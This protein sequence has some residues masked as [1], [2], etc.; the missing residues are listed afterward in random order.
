M[1][2]EPASA[3]FA[4][5]PITKVPSSISTPPELSLSASITSLPTPV[6][7]NL[8]EPEITPDIFCSNL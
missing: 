4:L 1:V 8:L 7:T 5:F 2:P 6:L 3:S